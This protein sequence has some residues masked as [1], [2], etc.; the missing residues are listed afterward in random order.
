LT[1]AIKQFLT[2]HRPFASRESAIFTELT[3][4]RFAEL[5]QKQ[6]DFREKKLN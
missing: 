1:H 6:T 3:T 2:L 5:A 4:S